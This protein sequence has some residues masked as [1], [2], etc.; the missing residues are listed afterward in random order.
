MVEKYWWFFRF[1]YAKKRAPQDKVLFLAITRS[2]LYPRISHTQRYICILQRSRTITLVWPGNK[3]TP[4]A[5]VRRKPRSGNEGSLQVHTMYGGMM[6][7]SDIWADIQRQGMSWLRT[8][9]AQSCV[10]YLFSN[11][12]PYSCQIGI[13]MPLEMTSVGHTEGTRQL[14]TTLVVCVQGSLRNHSLRK[15]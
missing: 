15:F 12:C 6:N 9:G 4:K 3:G 8:D 11:N 1:R 7:Y 10:L 14:V 13:E 2:S 5:K